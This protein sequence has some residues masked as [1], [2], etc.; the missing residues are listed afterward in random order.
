MD[1][2]LGLY[3]RVEEEVHTL[4]AKSNRCL[5]RL[6]HVQKI[7][8]LEAEFGKVRAGVAGAVGGP[9]ALVTTPRTEVCSASALGPA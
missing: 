5:E 8:E 1:A 2:A 3:N 7:R 6:E 9:Q 4:V